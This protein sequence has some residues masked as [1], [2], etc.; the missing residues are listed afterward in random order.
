MSQP[1]LSR[2]SNEAI[3][4]SQIAEE[5]RELKLVGVLQDDADDDDDEVA[6]SDSVQKTC[7][8]NVVFFLVGPNR[9]VGDWPGGTRST[10]AK[11]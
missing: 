3:R 10:P 9:L 2:L 1:E 8:F 5:K 6:C 4:A 11:C 7:S